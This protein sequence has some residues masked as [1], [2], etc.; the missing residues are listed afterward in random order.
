MLLVGWEFKS[1]LSSLEDGDEE[2]FS[3]RFIT[4]EDLFEQVKRA[5]EKAHIQEYSEY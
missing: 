3:F 5:K 1:A 2:C 4:V